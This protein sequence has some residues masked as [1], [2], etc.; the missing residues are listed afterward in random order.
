MAESQAF[1]V[2]VRHNIVSS[3]GPIPRHDGLHIPET[4]LEVSTQ[5]ARNHRARGCIDGDYYFENAERAKH[6][7]ALCQDFVKKLIDKTMADLER[8]RASPD[9]AWRNPSVFDADD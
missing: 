8:V 3:I 9:A 2:R 1:R 7:A 4:T 6:F 5:L